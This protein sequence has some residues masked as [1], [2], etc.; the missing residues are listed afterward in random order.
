MKVLRARTLA[1]TDQALQELYRLAEQWFREQP[2]DQQKG[3]AFSMKSMD[4]ITWEQTKRI[5]AMCGELSKQTT[6][7]GQKLD[8]DSWRHVMVAGLRRDTRTVQGL[9]GG[10]VLLG[11]SSRELSRKEC[12]DLIELIYS[13]GANQ[14]PAVVFKEKKEQK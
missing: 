2:A 6:L 11:G 9:D 7:H 1:G 8:K 14:E 4:L 5:N 10:L 3:L 12:G 13:Y